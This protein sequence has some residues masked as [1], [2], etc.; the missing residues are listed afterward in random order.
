MLS[1]IVTLLLILPNILLAQHSIK[2]V[3]SPAKNYEVVLLYKVTPTVSEYIKNTEI[4][5]DGSFQIQLE[6]SAEAGIY[7]I[8][9]AVPQED[10]NFDVIYNA[11]EDIELAFNAETGVTFKTSSENKLL[12]SYTKSMSMVTQSITNYYRGN[13]KDTTALNTIFKTQRETQA[14]YEKQAA[15]TIALQFIKANK[16]YIPKK[17]EDVKTYINHLK[18]RYFDNID[19][20]NKTLQSSSFLEERM[21]NYIFGM[22]AEGK[23]KIANYKANI[24][25]FCMA[26]KSAPAT[27]KRILLVSLWQQMRDLELPAVANYIAT[28][29]LIDIAKSLKDTTLVNDLTRYKNLSIGNKAPD[30]YIDGIKGKTK[31]TKKL[32]ELNTAKHYII[33]F[34][35]STCSHCLNDIPK[36]ETYLETKKAGSI[37]V[38]AIGLEDDDKI[39][40]EKIKS[41]PNFIHMLGLGK[42]SNS[43]GDD[44]GVELTPAYFVLDKDKKIVAKPFDTE[45]LK[46]FFDKNELLQ[47][48]K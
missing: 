25:A 5:N 43:I 29:Y 28:T 7:R 42:W 12:A 45:A 23:D 17:Y 38:V 8:V 2:G 44:Y 39:W 3:F 22:T 19:F 31:I 34:W 21:N 48:P 46:A 16:P 26:M 33:V 36:L 6:A 9:Y 15:N 1:K 41:F 47:V 20:N 35:S 4:N 37:E 27:V 13:K 14:R 10:Y 11:K 32:S 24:D 18:T 40:K 30:F